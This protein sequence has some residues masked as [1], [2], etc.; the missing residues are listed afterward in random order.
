MIGTIWELG[1]YS[2]QPTTRPGT[3]MAGGFDARRA[4]R[5]RRSGQPAGH[6][7][8]GAKQVIDA[9]TVGH[10]LAPIPG[11][12]SH[13]QNAGADATDGLHGSGCVF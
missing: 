10:E 1:T 8:T 3:D 11:P 12:A 9:L 5:A 13:T 7:A 6:R 4:G 2:H